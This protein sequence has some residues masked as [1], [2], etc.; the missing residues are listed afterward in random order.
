MRLIRRTSDRVNED[1]ST[2]RR[3]LV[4]DDDPSI[5]TLI[6][7]TLKDPRYE[8][9][10]ATNGLEALTAFKQEHFDVVIL[11]VMMPYVDGF[12]ACERIREESDIPIVMLTS[13]DGTED[14]VHGFELGADDYITKPFKTAELIARVE[15]ILRRVEGYKNRVAPATVRVGD[16]EIDEPRHRVVVR[17]HEVN[18]TPME[19]EL[20]YFLAANAGNVFDRETLFRE[21][22]GYDY[23]GETNLVDVCVRRL[24]EKVEIEP[25]RPRII[26]TIRGVGYKLTNT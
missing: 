19:F 18:L 23:V 25:S 3:I 4:A 5:A 22:W 1:S 21:V 9:I 6:Q 14:I 17:G 11:D 20:L 24:R 7:V 10:A 16:I 2:P 15:S 8:V 12:E 13:R 26:V